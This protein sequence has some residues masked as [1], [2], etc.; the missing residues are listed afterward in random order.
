M[1]ALLSVM[2]SETPLRGEHDAIAKVMERGVR[3]DVSFDASLY[4]A[5]AVERLREAWRW[6]MAF[7]HRSST[8]FSQLAGQLVEANATI[9]AKVV[10]LRL[11]QDELRHTETCGEVI[12]A[13]GGDSTVEIDTDVPPLARH[14]GTSAEERALRNVIYTTCMSEMVACARFVDTLD[15]MSDPYLREQTRRLLS[16]EVM[17]G[18]FGFH[19]LTAWKPWLDANPDTVRSIEKFLTI[20]FFTLEQELAPTPPF[21]R[22]PTPDEDAMGLDSS[23]RAREVFYGTIEH[24]VIPGLERFGIDA[25]KAYRER[26]APGSTSVR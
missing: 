15:R 22:P 6:R 17:H 3:K 12:R 7:E 16:D 9:D 1:R 26:R 14:P 8:V 19:Y 21:G 20:G 11:A 2:L 13:M 25:G 24:A 5:G 4:D 10:M 18:Q 23:E